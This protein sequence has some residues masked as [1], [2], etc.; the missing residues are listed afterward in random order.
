MSVQPTIIP[1]PPVW[2]RLLAPVPK[3]HPIPI[4]K[5]RHVYE[6][7]N[8]YRD[9]QKE[10]DDLSEEE[11]EIEDQVSALKLVEVQHYDLLCRPWQ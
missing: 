5:H 2:P 11:N 4:P 6:N 7:L 1:K 3:K 10:M 8:Y 9:L